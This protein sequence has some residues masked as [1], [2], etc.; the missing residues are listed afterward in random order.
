M[1][2]LPSLSLTLA[3][4]AAAATTATA[5][6]IAAKTNAANFSADEDDLSWSCSDGRRRACWRSDPNPP[7][8][9]LLPLPLLL[10]ATLIGIGHKDI[11]SACGIVNRG[12]IAPSWHCGRATCWRRSGLCCLLVHHLRLLPILP[13]TNSLNYAFISLSSRSRRMRKMQNQHQKIK[14]QQILQKRLR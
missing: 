6:F 1:S 13:F 9:M 8:F 14:P 7:L 10:L 2:P 12:E 4:A 3:A 11:N 5:T